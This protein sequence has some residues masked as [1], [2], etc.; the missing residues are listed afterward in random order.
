MAL[1]RCPD[2]G[3]EVSDS[4]LACPS[5]ARPFVRTAIHSLPPPRMRSSSWRSLLWVVPLC[6]V[7]MC[8]LISI[9]NVPTSS[10]TAASSPSGDSRPAAASR[11]VSPPVK[12][13]SWRW[14]A[15]P[16]FTSDGA[17]IFTAV[18]RNTSSNPI[19]SVRLEFTS[20]DAAGRILDTQSDYATGLPPGGTA[21]SKGYATY[22][23][24]EKTATLVI[25]S[26]R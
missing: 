12:I 6:F 16:N 25:K 22:F 13:E 18:V 7:G 8:T 10:T 15:D 19:R 14:E 2:C 5:C 3:R 20:F 9:A 23:G 17:V 21:S 24:T 26:W 4:A 11:A 1:I